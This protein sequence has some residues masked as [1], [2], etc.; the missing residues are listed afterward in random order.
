MYQVLY[1]S[2]WTVGS[3]W[4]ERLVSML[5]SL[6]SKLWM[7]GMTADWMCSGMAGSRRC[8]H[9]MLLTHP[10]EAKN[11]FSCVLGARKPFPEG[12]EWTPPDT[13]LNRTRPHGHS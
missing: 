6:Y 12:P 1:L 8:A 9:Q 13:S 11:Q 5:R 7:V 2:K 3:S 4:A 10:E